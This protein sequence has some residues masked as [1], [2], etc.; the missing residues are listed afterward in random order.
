MLEG[1]ELLPGQNPEQT[2]PREEVGEKVEAPN[3]MAQSLLLGRALWNRLGRVSS[4]LAPAPWTEFFIAHPEI[5]VVAAEV[6]GISQD[7]PAE[8]TA[9]L[10]SALPVPSGFSAG[11]APSKSVP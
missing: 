9:P 10:D 6:P 7:V 5:P 2:H 1:K 8:L 11:S 4:R 3:L